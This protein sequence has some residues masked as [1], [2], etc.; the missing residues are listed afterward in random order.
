MTRLDKLL[1]TAGA[2]S[3][4]EL[5]ELIRQG[6][7]LVDGAPATACAQLC[8]PDSSITIDGNPVQRGT[9]LYLMLHKRAGYLSATASGREPTVLELLP[10][11]LRQRQL[12][13]VGRL[14]LDT[15]GLLLLTSDGDFCHRLIDPDREIPKTYYARLQ[16]TP[17]QDAAARFA[18][19]LEIDSGVR[20]R[21]AVLWPV[22]GENGVLVQIT[23]GKRH[24]VKRMLAAVGARVTYLQ[25]LAIGQLLLDPDLPCGGCRPLEP[26]EL[27]LALRKTGPSQQTLLAHRKKLK[28]PAVRA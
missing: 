6:R 1:R 28:N 17:A 7:V 2:A 8:G 9:D 13:P 23:E 14:D 15:E 3:R 24:Q 20:C 22:P 21:P 16:G 12:F 25:R 4:K 19:G 18:R 10:P 27:E 26:Q 5:A 11:A